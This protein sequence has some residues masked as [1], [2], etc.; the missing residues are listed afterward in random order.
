MFSDRELRKD[1]SIMNGS[2]KWGRFG[3][4]AD[5]LISLQGVIQEARYWTYATANGRPSR[6]SLKRCAAA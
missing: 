5:F 6:F 2:P 4:P 3:L 1:K